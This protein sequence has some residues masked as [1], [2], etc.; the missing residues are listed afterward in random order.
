M[1][2]TK[3]TA[4]EY[5]NFLNEWEWNCHIT[6][7][8]K[9]EPDLSSALKQARKY[10]N[11]LKQDQHKMKFTAALLATNAH[12]RTHVHILICCDERYPMTINNVGEFHIKRH[13]L[14][15]T[16]RITTSDEWENETITEYLT[17]RK[18]LNLHDP[19]SYNLDFYRPALLRQLQRGKFD[20][21]YF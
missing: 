16:A 10:L 8:F 15:G 13:W 18:N 12:H 17:K 4:H 21:K 14:Q 5:Q 19:D 7:T 20:G 9:H 1:R 2:Y 3:D 11:K 6:L